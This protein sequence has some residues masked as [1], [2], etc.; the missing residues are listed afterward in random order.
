MRAGTEAVPLI[1]GMAKAL[2]NVQ[3]N[4]KETESKFRELKSYLIQELNPISGISY[5]AG[6][7]DDLSIPSLINLSLD[8]EKFNEMTLFQLDLAGIA[9]SGGS[10]CSSGAIKGSHVLGHLDATNENIALRISFSKYTIKEE[11]DYFIDIL[12]GLES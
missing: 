2:E 10:A 5:H 4:L 11:L 12:R 3:T 6:S 1:M 7:A 9:V 8:K